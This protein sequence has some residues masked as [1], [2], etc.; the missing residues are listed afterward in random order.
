MREV[1]IERKD[2]RGW[3]VDLRN[4]CPHSETIG[5]ALRDTQSC[6]EEARD[7]PYTRIVRETAFACV[8]TLD[9]GRATRRQN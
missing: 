8:Y 7:G 3:V 2:C 6:A 5:R 1:S 4:T 9:K